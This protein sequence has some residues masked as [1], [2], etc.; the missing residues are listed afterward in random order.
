MT[1]S[2]PT[3]SRQVAPANI[4]LAESVQFPLGTPET[5][6]AEWAEFE[7]ILAA[8]ANRLANVAEGKFDEATTTCL[9]ELTEF[10]AF[11]RGTILI[12]SEHIGSLRV[13]HSWA[14]P[15]VPRPTH[16]TA[17]DITLSWYTHQIRS[18]YVVRISSPDDL[19]STAT[20]E[21]AYLLE[22]GLKSHISIPLVIEHAVIGAIAFS[23]FHAERQLPRSMISRLR[24]VGEVLGLA[25]RR[26]QYADGLKALALSV[27]HMS[28]GPTQQDRRHDE[29][30]RRLAMH[31]MHVERQERRRMG[32]VVHEDV[33]QLLASIGMFLETAR[34]GDTEARASAISTTQGLLRRAL[35]KLRQ[36]AMELRPAALSATGFAEGVHWLADQMRR[37]HGMN[38]DV[39]ADGTIEPVSEDIKQFLYDAAMKLLQQL[40]THSQRKHARIEIRRNEPGCIQMIMIDEGAGFTPAS[41]DNSS[42]ISPALFSIQEQAEMLGGRL[43]V[44]N[45]PG[46]GTRVSVTVPA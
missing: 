19:P 3:M 20:R 38:V 9:R 39:Q 1:N 8:V 13:A 30:L 16:D 14:T 23:A 27:D 32:D 28:R 40:T 10:L 42:G 41:K 31:L 18:G 17:V 46:E 37:T 7:T 11:D 44:H 33:M 15:G 26:Q 34:K 35:R 36:L 45:A 6:P 5:V 12:F 4:P 22:S 29:H 24:L 2:Q 21:R 25:L 43:D